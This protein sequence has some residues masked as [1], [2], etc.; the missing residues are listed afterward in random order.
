MPNF[1]HSPVDI[2]WRSCP[3]LFGHEVSEYGHLRRVVELDNHSSRYPAGRMYSF[4]LAGKGYPFYSVKVGDKRKNFYAHKL[5]AEAF[6]GEQPPGTEVAHNDNDKLN[7]HYTNLRYASPK[8][9]N[10]DKIAHG[11]YVYGDNHPF[12]KLKTE[13]AD[14]VMAMRRAG[15]SQRL[16]GERLSVSQTA[17]GR[18]IQRL[19]NANLQAL[20]A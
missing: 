8:E 17:V 2:E 5:V 3:S 4:G 14:E 18:F 6:I 12:V 11:T 13:H 16:I 15:L 1:K 7:S 19:T 10:A 9:N 20:T